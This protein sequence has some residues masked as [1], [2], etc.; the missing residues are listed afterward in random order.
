[1]PYIIRGQRSTVNGRAP[2][3]A[4]AAQPTAEEQST[5]PGQPANV[6]QAI[7]LQKAYTAGEIERGA[8]IETAVSVGKIDRPTAEKLFPLAKP[9]V[10]TPGTAPAS[11]ATAP[12]PASNP[13]KGQVNM[14]LNQLAAEMNFSTDALK[15][16][17][18]LE[19]SD[20]EKIKNFLKTNRDKPG[21]LEEAR[22]DPE[23]VIQ[24]ED[25]SWDEIGTILKLNRDVVA[26]LGTFPPN[27]QELLKKALQLYISD[28][29]QPVAFSEKSR[30]MTPE[31]RAELLSYSGI[32]QQILNS[33]KR[34]PSASAFSQ[35]PHSKSC[36]T[37]ERRAE[38]LAGYGGIGRLILDSE[39]KTAAAF[40][41][42][43]PTAAHRRREM[44]TLSGQAART[45]KYQQR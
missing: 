6:Y 30:G 45:L 14:D 29:G 20:Q 9:T 36:M 23:S 5:G 42:K 21:V 24:P 32:G 4:F 12:P 25:A 13:A 10:L 39:K 34:S 7:A 18:T 2:L 1:M 3:K 35:K 19:L 41:A 26:C 33:E 16:L 8:A 37:P 44:L 22:A 38:L 11:Q 15:V 28:G 40:S 17:G 31:R 27:V 43:T